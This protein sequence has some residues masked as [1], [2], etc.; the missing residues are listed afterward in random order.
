MTILEKVPRSSPQ[1]LG[2]E[3]DSTVYVDDY[4]GS[5]EGS[6]INELVSVGAFIF[7]VAG[8]IEKISKREGPDQK[9]ALLGFLFNTLQHLL[10]IPETKSKE[11]LF[12]IESIL[13]RVDARQSVS[14]QEFLSLIG[15]LTWA[16]SAIVM[17]R[18]YLRQVRKPLIAVQLD[19][20]TR[21]ELSLIHI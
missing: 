16:G 11:I 20:L 17:G 19:L 3:P 8:L 9:L 5:A 18:A 21:R 6:W 12:Q 15:K 4:M 2:T 14:F 13:R 7:Q 10:S 1:A